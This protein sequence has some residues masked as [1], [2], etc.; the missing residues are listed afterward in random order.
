MED[1]E[2]L[3]LEKGNLEDDVERVKTELKDIRSYSDYLIPYMARIPIPS[4]NFSIVMRLI[5]GFEVEMP[6]DDAE[7]ETQQLI[8]QYI[9]H[10]E[11]IDKGALLGCLVAELGHHR[12]YIGIIKKISAEMYEEAYVYEEA[13]G[14]R[15]V[16]EV[17]KRHAEDI[18]SWILIAAIEHC[19]PWPPIFIEWIE[20]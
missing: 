4:E 18:A 14:A 2:K 12:E 8:L 17:A 3:K 19:Y 13:Y 20:F 1:F 16:I 10:P 7:I 6:Q 9:T 11:M 5:Q 15:R